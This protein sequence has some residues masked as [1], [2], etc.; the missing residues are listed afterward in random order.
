MTREEVF[1]GVKECLGKVLDIP[2]ESIRED[3][4]IIHDLGADSLDFLDLS[5][6]LQQK[7]GVTFSPRDDERRLQE[8]MGGIAIQNN[9]VYTPEALAELRQSMPDIPAE[10]LSDGLTVSA[11]PLLFRVSTI[12]NLILRLKE[13][14]SVE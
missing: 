9:G 8:K 7:F 4:R 2:I 12:V 13:V 11:L 5:F 3:S 6:H 1:E 14:G 10:E